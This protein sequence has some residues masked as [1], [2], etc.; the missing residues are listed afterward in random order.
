MNGE[1]ASEHDMKARLLERLAVDTLG[2]TDCLWHFLHLFCLSFIC[3]IGCVSPHTGQICIR[4]ALVCPRIVPRMFEG[5]KVGWNVLLY[6][7]IYVDVDVDVRM[8]LKF[9]TI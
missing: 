9:R 4:D 7:S 6:M 2:C 8:H 1:T 5:P 3:L